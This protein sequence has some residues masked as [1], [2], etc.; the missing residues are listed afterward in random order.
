[1]RV[2]IPT[3]KNDPPAWLTIE[4]NGVLSRGP[5][6][7][8]KGSTAFCVPTLLALYTKQAGIKAGYLFASLTGRSL[9]RAKVN[10]KKPS[11]KFLANAIKR[12]LR[13]IGANPSEMVN[14]TGHS[15]RRTCTHSSTFPSLQ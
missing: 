7:Q 3:H 14:I 6:E 8:V 5:S 11:N 2:R 10:P 12:L 13:L 1:M 4:S 9:A 15:T